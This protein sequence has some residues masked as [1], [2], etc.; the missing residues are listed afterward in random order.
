MT[1]YHTPARPAFAVLFP[2]D[3]RNA[4]MHAAGR[5]DVDA[6]DRLTDELARMGL[7]RPRTCEGRAA[8]WATQRVLAKASAP[9]VRA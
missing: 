2:V 5:G 3:H 9:G 4:L 1:T 7:V 6:I 8:E